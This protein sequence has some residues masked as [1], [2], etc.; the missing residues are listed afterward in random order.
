LKDWIWANKEWFFSGMGGT[1]F[2]I[3]WGVI[4]FFANCKKSNSKNI[5]LTQKNTKN[6]KGT[7][8][9]IQNNYGRK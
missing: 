6:S 5:I 7:Q 3:A 4:E 9:G 8:I 2:I 1:I